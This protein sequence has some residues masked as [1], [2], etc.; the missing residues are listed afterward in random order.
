MDKKILKERLIT[1]VEQ[2]QL[3]T[4]RFASF[5]KSDYEVLMF[6]A[7][8]DS[9]DKTEIND[10]EISIA[11]GITESK[12]RNLRVK[13]QLQYP[14]EIYWDKEL[15]S[16]IE[17]GT[18]D[19]VQKQITVTLEDPSVRNRIK[20]E[21]ESKF[22][23]VNLSLNNKQLVLPV[24]SFLVLA[25]CAEKDTDDVLKK[26]NK[27]LQNSGIKTI[28]KGDLKNRF[29]QNTDSVA[30][31]I[32]NLSIIYKAGAPLLSALLTLI[33]NTVA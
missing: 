25:A 21:V 33:M 32:A 11:L 16:A 1:R 23:T 30:D 2:A 22:G 7:Y 24:E 19:Q 5:N 31:I 4:N 8:L 9:L 17:H 26:L 20:Y 28:E 6:T 29:L 12:V 27:E 14:R 18:Y 15:T 3:Y 13:S 10:Y